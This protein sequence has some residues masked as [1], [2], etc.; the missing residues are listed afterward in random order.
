[1]KSCSTCRFWVAI[2]GTHGECRRR[3][4]QFIADKLQGRWP[5]VAADEWCGSYGIRVDLVAATPKLPP[6][7]PLKYDWEAIGALVS[8]ACG[9]GNPLPLV[10]RIVQQEIPISRPALHAAIIRFVADGQII[11]RDESG[12]QSVY[13]AA[14]PTEEL[15]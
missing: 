13:L 4:P 3:S 8:K 7:R 12:K 5:T 9:A 10:L 2:D 11:K 14:S 15:A 1:M 6:G